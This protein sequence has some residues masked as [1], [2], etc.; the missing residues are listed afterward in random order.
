M[1][2][3][4]GSK[5]PCGSSALPV[6][7]GRTSPPPTPGIRGPSE[8]RARVHASP[9]LQTQN[10]SCFCTGD[11]PDPYKQ[12]HPRRRLF[13]GLRVAARLRFAEPP[14]PALSFPTQRGAEQPALLLH[15]YPLE[16]F[17]RTKCLTRGLALSP[18]RPERK[19]IL[20]RGGVACTP[21]GNKLRC[22]PGYSVSSSSCPGSGRFLSLSQPVAL[23]SPFPFHGRQGRRKDLEGSGVSSSHCSSPPPAKDMEGPWDSSSRCGSIHPHTSHPH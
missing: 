19:S 12:P 20:R 8:S 22:G 6:A 17:S 10:A 16:A 15:F 2:C 14:S 3:L 7:E 13:E 11:P 21:P 1:V 9:S 4:K 5:A 18:Q 23:P